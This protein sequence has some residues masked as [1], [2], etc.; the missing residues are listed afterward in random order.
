VDAQQRRAGAAMTAGSPE[1]FAAAVD[2]ATATGAPGFEIRRRCALRRPGLRMLPARGLH[3]RP[4][5]RLDNTL[6]HMADSARGSIERE[7]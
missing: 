6:V 2:K 4:G 3:L 1:D 5:H 7:V